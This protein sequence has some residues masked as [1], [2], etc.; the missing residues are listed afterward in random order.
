MKHA[1]ALRLHFLAAVVNTCQEI[2]FSKT[3]ILYE[4]KYALII[5]KNP[6]L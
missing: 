2:D 4:N 1:E 6:S 5:Q 3:H